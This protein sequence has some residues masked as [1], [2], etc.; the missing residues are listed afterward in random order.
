MTTRSI[1]TANRGTGKRKS[2]KAT[3]T[4][5]APRP[6]VYERVTAKIIE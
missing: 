3:K 5:E 2:S 6:D 1:K 4:Y